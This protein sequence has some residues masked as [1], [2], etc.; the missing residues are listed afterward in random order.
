MHAPT[1][2]LAFSLSLLTACGDEL[3]LHSATGGTSSTSHSS[4]STSSSTS[5]G[6]GGASSNS[7]SSSA[8]GAGGSTSSSSGST[9]VGGGCATAPTFAEVLAKPLSGCSGMEPPCHNLGAAM[10]SINPNAAHF[11]WKQLVNVPAST[12][13]AGDRVVPGDPAHSFLYRKL[14]DDLTP[15]EGLPMPHTGL[16]TGW[17]ELPAD[18]REMV[19]CWIQAGAPD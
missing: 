10:L 8:G 19:R 17:N 13:G 14:I 16:A 7:S 1:L 6:A 18:Q 9:G 5:S 12:V 3:L 11:T 2:S 15:D 4:G